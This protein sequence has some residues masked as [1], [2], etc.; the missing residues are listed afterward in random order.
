[1][2]CDKAQLDT[3]TDQ[4]A[5]AQGFF[6]R[7]P[8]C[9]KN[10]LN[11]FCATTCDPN[12]SQFQDGTLEPYKDGYQVTSATVYLD[13]N[14]AHGVFNSCKN[15][16]NPGNNA[17][18]VVEIMCGD[19]TPCTTDAWFQYLGTGNPYVPFPMTY[20]FD[21]NGSL[22]KPKGMVAENETFYPCDYH[23]GA[24]YSLQ[25]SCTDCGTPKVCPPPPSLPENSFP[26][27]WIMIGIGGGGGL[28]VL[29]VF[30]VALIAGIVQLI[31]KP[32]GYSR[33]GGSGATS[34][35]YGTM[36]EGGDDSPTS[37]VG[38]INDDPDR[39]TD[40]RDD[41]AQTCICHGYF[42]FGAYF[43]YWIKRVFYLWGIF[44]TRFWYLVIIGGVIVMGAFASGMYK[45]EVV[46]DT[47]QLWSA[48]DSR[49]RIEK[50]YFDDN[51]GPFYRAEMIIVKPLN[52]SYYFDAPNA[53]SGT[54]RY[55]PAMAWNV[56]NE[57]SYNYLRIISNNYAD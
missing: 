50:N 31:L 53:G 49:A 55:G 43:E 9:L 14:Y 6:E 32:K 52:Q 21:N 44:V 34:S 24:D 46:T 36:P 30:I 39:D 23:D 28:V 11:I 16:I 19:A 42:K 35:S 54:A 3:L 29:L 51:F 22:P 33:I 57:V 8:A 4:I 5:T 45:F 17:Q 15:V 2:C 40:V 12:M 41:G 38:S 27:K 20:K 7:C 47:V 13:D 10:F 1:M 48:P 18:K 25:C 56:L 37:S 26:L